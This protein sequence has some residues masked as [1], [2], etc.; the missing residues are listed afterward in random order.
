ML[1]KLE[2]IF[3]VTW[4]N[5]QFISIIL[6]LALL[7][8]SNCATQRPISSNDDALSSRINQFYES[9]EQ[10]NYG[11]C[12][13]FW[14]PEADIGSKKEYVDELK[15]WNLR[16]INHEIMSLAVNGIKGEARMQITTKEGEETRTD[17]HFDYWVLSNG[18]W[19]LTDVR[20]ERME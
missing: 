8:N 4:R 3:H 16:F 5:S 17:Y 14:L 12:W 19:Y 1:R 15:K 7:V 2:K 11:K 18:K 9:V 20:T 10:Q 13:S 6:T